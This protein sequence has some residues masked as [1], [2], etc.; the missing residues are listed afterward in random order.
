MP[1]PK[2]TSNQGNSRPGAISVSAHW[3][4]ICRSRPSAAATSSG[5]NSPARRRALSSSAAHAFARPRYRS[6]CRLSCAMRG[7]PDACAGSLARCYVTD[8]SWLGERLRTRPAGSAGG[9]F[10]RH[11]FCHIFRPCI[12]KA[13]GAVEHR[14]A[15]RRILVEAEIALTLELHR[16]LGFGVRSRRLDAGLK[17]LQ[18]IRIEVRG[19]PFAAARIRLAEQRIV[20]P[21][22]RGETLRR[23]H[24]VDGAL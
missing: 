10:F 3:P 7:A 23:R 9:F 1:A 6:P 4:R 24:P 22:L 8:R 13:D 17:N 20:E 11:V 12:A 19:E 2:A 15:G 16:L 21:D 5:S 18:R 14:F